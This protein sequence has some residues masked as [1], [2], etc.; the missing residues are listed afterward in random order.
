[1][2]QQILNIC[3]RVPVV[4]LIAFAA[5]LTYVATSV[6]KITFSQLDSL[7]VVWYRVGFAALILLAWRKPWKLDKKYLP[8]GVK[9]WL[10]VSAA[11]VSI[12]LMNTAFYFAITNMAIGIAVSIEFLG[13]LT[14]AVCTGRLWQE[15]IG[16]VIASIGVVLLANASMHSSSAG[17]FWLG[18]IAV[19]FSGSMW[20]LYIITGRKLAHLGHPIDLLSIALTVGWIVQSVGLAIPAVYHVIIPKPSATWVFAPY[21]RLWL[22]LLLLLV[23]VFTNFVPVLLDQVIM[24][25]ASSASYSVLQSIYPAMALFVDVLFGVFPNL[26]EVLG[27]FLVIIAVIITF[28]GDNIVR[29]MKFK[30]RRI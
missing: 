16:I 11:G 3:N 8:Q 25:R 5:L 1:M 9:Q 14:V 4:V 29:H 28:S 30:A 10:L 19:L 26:L 15:R 12:T 27:V 17:N 18:F 7:Y 20:G 24:R 21:G 23:A 2:K 13:P 22:V 6:A